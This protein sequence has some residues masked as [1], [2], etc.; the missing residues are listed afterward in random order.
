MD[1]VL[2][3]AEMGAADRRAVAAGTPVAV[4]MERAGR[5]VAWAVRTHLGRTYGVRAV[6][7]CGKGDNGGD[8][9][10]AARVLTGWGAR[11]D[12]LRV[13]AG[14]DPVWVERTVARADVVVDA[15]YGTGFRGELGGDAR[16]VVDAVAARSD[17]VPV[18]AV[19]VPSGVDGSTGAVSGPAVRATRTVTFAARK[20][21]LLFEPGR[22]LAG[23]VTVADIGIAVDPPPGVPVTGC[24]RRADVAAWLPARPLEAH[25]WT[26]AVWV[27][28][29][30]AGMTGAPALAAR[31]ALRSGAGMVWCGVPGDAA[32]AGGEV[33]GVALPA[34]P[35]GGLGDAAVD[36]VLADVGRFGALAVGPGLGRDPGTLAAVRRLVLAA[37][38]PVVLDADGIHAFAGDPGA[39]RARPAP[40]VC[41]PHAG[42]FAVLTGAPPGPD[43]LAAARASAEATGCV[44]LLKGPGT[45]V[46]DP[47]GSAA[48]CPI[49]GPELAT[50]GTGDVLTGIVAAA[51]ARGAG[52]FAAA[53][54]GA[55]IHA[56]AA[57]VAG[58]TVLIAGDLVGSLPAV[59]DAL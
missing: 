17:P 54:A 21:G 6:I 3:P 23:E 18:I 56:A 58:H 29:G 39:L 45:V 43:R 1:P 51:L 59:L 22:S 19:D 8:G 16:L 44:V 49:G 55:W 48:I 53:A 25:K 38:V 27:V 9:L 5:A 50:A 36:R 10:V 33:I 32:V 24:P 34:G 14:L 20:P 13:G 57:R 46:A 40:T 28:G 4:L 30:S 26:A 41:T 11:V 12:V 47:D 35:G 2:T 42:E 15:M 52:A 31:A 37:P 7:A